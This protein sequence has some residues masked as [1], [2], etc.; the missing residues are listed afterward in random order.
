MTTIDEITIAVKQFINDYTLGL[1]YPI[2]TEPYVEPAEQPSEPKGM[3]F[4]CF[5]I[6]IRVCSQWT[7]RFLN[8]FVLFHF[9]LLFVIAQLNLSIHYSFSTVLK[10]LLILNFV[11]PIFFLFSCHSFIL[12]TRPFCSL[13]LSRAKHES[14]GQDVPWFGIVCRFNDYLIEF[15]FFFRKLRGM[16]S[17]ACS[18]S[19]ATYVEPV[20]PNPKIFP[21][22]WQ[23]SGENSDEKRYE[24]LEALDD[25]V[26]D[27]PLP[28]VFMLWS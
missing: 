5:S 21:K 16:V 19:M 11:R 20:Y 13:P 22:S 24:D 25:D 6:S 9:H 2:P 12:L 27:R 18:R 4:D 8:V 23:S 1:A 28:T 3:N 17:V 7:L 26:R 10:H 15:P 14:T